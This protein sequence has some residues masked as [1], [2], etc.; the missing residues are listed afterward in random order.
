MSDSYKVYASQEYVDNKIQEIDTS[1]DWNAKEGE[2][3]YIE[4]RTHYEQGGVFEHTYQQELYGTPDYVVNFEHGYVL[5]NFGMHYITDKEVAFDELNTSLTLELQYQ[6]EKYPVEYV[7]DSNLILNDKDW[8]CAIRWNPEPIYS[9]ANGN[10]NCS[11]VLSYF[12]T[13]G[14]KTEFY[15][16]AY[17]NPEPVYV[18]KP[19]LYVSASVAMA[20]LQGKLEAITFNLGE[21]SLKTLDNKFLSDDV[22][23]A[24]PI[25]AKPAVTVL[26]ETVCELIDDDGDGSLE[27]GF[28]PGRWETDFE[29]GRVYKVNYNGTEYICKALLVEDNGTPTYLLGNT[30]AEGI[31][32][33]NSEA[34]FFMAAVPN[35]YVDE[36]GIE[37]CAMVMPLNTLDSLT[38]SITADEVLLNPQYLVMDTDGNTK[39][40][41][42]THWDDLS[43]I[44]PK[45]DY[46]GDLD[47]TYIFNPPTHPIEEGRIYTVE[48]EGVIFETTFTRG[49]SDTHGETYAS[50]VYRDDQNR[51]FQINLFPYGS[52]SLG[53]IYGIASVASFGGTGSTTDGTFK[54][55][56]YIHAG[57]IKTLDP[58]YL[59]AAPGKS[60]I[61][62]L[63]K[64]TLTVSDPND[65]GDGAPITT[66]FTEYPSAGDTWNVTYNG[67]EYACELIDASTIP[68]LELPLPEG[69]WYFGGNLTAGGFEH[70]ASNNDAP[71][72][73]MAAGSEEFAV[74]MEAYGMI[75]PIV[76]LDQ[77]FTVSITKGSQM[78]PS[79]LTLRSNGEM[80]WE[81]RPF[82]EEKNEVVILPLS[83][84][85]ADSEEGG[86][87]DGDG[88]VDT[89]VIEGSLLNYPAIGAKGT[90]TVNGTEYES[91]FVD[92][93][94]IL[95]DDL[96]EDCSL[97]ACGNVA[98]LGLTGGN[99][100]APL[101]CM[102]PG[103]EATA[104]LMATAGGVYIFE[105]ELEGQDITIS[106][107]MVETK[108]KKLDSKFVDVEMPYY[109]PSSVPTENTL[110]LPQTSLEGK[111]ETS[112]FGRVASN[113]TDYDFQLKDGHEYTIVCD[114]AEYKAICSYH[115]GDMDLSSGWMLSTN[116]QSN[117]LTAS[118]DKG[119][120]IWKSETGVS[121]FGK[122]SIFT[123]LEISNIAIKDEAKFVS[124]LN[125]K[126][127]SD[128]PSALIQGSDVRSVQHR[129]ARSAS[130][131][132]FAWGIDCQATG[133]SAVAWGEQVKAYAA[134]AFARGYATQ[135]H[136]QNSS[137]F[138]SNNI[139]RG[140]NAFVIGS[141]HNINSDNVF[142]AGRSS[143]DNSNAA[144]ILGNGDSATSV[145]SNASIVDWSGNG[146]FAGDLYVNGDG[147][148][149]GFDGAK[150]VATEELVDKKAEGLAAE[151]VALPKSAGVVDHGTAGQ[152]AVSDGMGGIMWKTLVEAEEV[153]Y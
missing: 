29:E 88:L 106:I 123:Y 122:N 117:Y 51:Y 105:G 92:C 31:S 58:K 43:I 84:C 59:A 86:D 127:I 153:A 1:V 45:G 32:G 35:S 93:S 22:V 113:F 143:L 80:V 151:M 4:N 74:E 129:N 13:A 130:S 3:G 5:S 90:I 95:G 6:G 11:L 87:D 18:T 67:I 114:G 41:D 24:A 8:H 137:S 19:G 64:T 17:E 150:K 75:A 66:P 82:Y 134:N 121:I 10:L 149:I 103:N 14:D 102:L 63:P 71:F 132:G 148:T 20:M 85:V 96:P 77:T 119:I 52:K 69:A 68:S 89:Y 120:I 56:L 36:N 110:I 60:K 26:N 9:A 65:P 126:L 46:P 70:V 62:I 33:G 50:E 2:P 145:K 115:P 128:Y 99:S 91:E 83:N 146:Y 30:E 12:A 53:P 111:F 39:W 49:Y 28:I 37:F 38:I 100:D 152:F 116:G 144:Y 79:Q 104:Q 98:V 42:R 112:A 48:L 133:G 72:I 109:L 27:G 142:V 57:S 107:K 94:P 108:I 76:T 101:A 124:H 136:G 54:Q 73:I 15:A 141:N 131:G 16:A 118:V 34:P 147:Q 47:G 23:I 140:A 21:Y 55:N 25:K 125:T 44:V 78:A 135:I 97:I 81:E 138:G 7:V 139:I 40:Q 61:T